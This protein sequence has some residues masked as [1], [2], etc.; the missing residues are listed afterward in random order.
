MQEVHQQLQR[1]QQELIN[2]QL[3]RQLVIQQLQQALFEQQ[4]QLQQDIVGELQ[5]QT[6]SEGVRR[7]DQSVGV[8]RISTLAQRAPSQLR[9]YGVLESQKW[10]PWSIYG[11]SWLQSGSNSPRTAW[12]S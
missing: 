7:L 2:Q 11:N 9:P 12:V 10:N 3:A 5:S 1:Q 8:S 6:W 4:Q